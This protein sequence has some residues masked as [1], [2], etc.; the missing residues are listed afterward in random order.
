[1]DNSSSNSNLWQCQKVAM[2]LVQCWIMSLLFSVINLF[3]FSWYFSAVTAIVI[4]SFYCKIITQI[5]WKFLVIAIPN[6]TLSVR[7]GEGGVNTITWKALENKVSKTKMHF[8]LPWPVFAWLDTMSRVYSH[9]I[10]RKTGNILFYVSGQLRQLKFAEARS[11]LNSPNN[12][13]ISVNQY[14]N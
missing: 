13:V 9:K 12:W 3:L 7:R 8:H 2:I 11:M 14:I 5:Y 4:S 1:M 6:I 10:P